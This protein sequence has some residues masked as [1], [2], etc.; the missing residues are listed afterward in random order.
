MAKLRVALL[1]GINVGRAKRVAMEDL[2]NLFTSLGCGDVTTLLNSGNVVFSGPA[3]LSEARIEKAFAERFGFSSRIT[4]VAGSELIAA[5]E[6]NP[7][8]EIPDPSRFL[9]AFPKNAEAFER[10]R[11]LEERTWHPDILA[12]GTRVAYL[13]CHE[14][15]LDSPLNQALAKALGDSV[16]A[17][18]WTTV[19]K[20]RALVEG[21]RNA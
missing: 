7:I 19:L 1:R 4:V 20:L 21:S 2:R 10:L 9:V 16:T 5:V 17:R 13:W 6:E 11:A 14:G 15:V 18:N 3:A 12:I 8:A